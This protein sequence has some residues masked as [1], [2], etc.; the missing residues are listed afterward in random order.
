MNDTP[1]TASS[2]VSQELVSDRQQRRCCI[3]G[4]THASP[5]VAPRSDGERELG[6]CS[7]EPVPRVNIG[8]KFVVAAANILDK[9]VADADHSY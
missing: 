2:Q 1:T 9:G 7:R 8:G 6:K 3:D 5:S 4:R